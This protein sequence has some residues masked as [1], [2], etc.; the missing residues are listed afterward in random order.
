VSPATLQEPVADPAPTTYLVCPV[1]GSDLSS[2]QETAVL[3]CAGCGATY[4]AADG[5]PILLAEITDETRQRYLDNYERVAEADLAEPL[6]PYR[7]ARHARLASF[8]GDVRGKTVLEIGSSNG[9]FL[10][11]IDAGFKVAF[12]IALPYLRVI[13]DTDKLAAVCG[14]AEKLPFRRG[15]FDVVILSDVLEHV[16]DPQAVVDEVARISQPGTR[17]IVEVPWEEDLSSYGENAE[18]EF[19]HL[20]SFDLFTFSTLW[21]HFRIVR[22]RSTVPRLDFPLFLQDRRTLPLGLL[23]RLRL[24]YHHH[25]FA[26]P[27]F[28]WRTRRLE[29]LPRHD[30]LLTALSRPLVRQFELTPFTEDAIERRPTGWLDRFVERSLQ[31]V[32]RH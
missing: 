5:I 18:W 13:P 21:S 11:R 6:E 19:T 27:D 15:F 1:C 17:V 7:E 32:Y 24:L 10:R 28:A 26:E 12:D 29:R 25:G 9:L 4:E 14:D 23:N 2:S 30:A 22:M 31:I 20:R 8:I 3:S 16:L